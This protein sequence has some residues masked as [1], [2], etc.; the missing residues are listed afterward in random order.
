MNELILIVE[1]NESILFNL[2][3][4]LEMND[5]Q[6][7]TATDA[8]QA[9]EILKNIEELPDLIL[10]DIMMP[11]LNGYEFFE[12]ISKDKKLNHIPFVF[13]SAKSLPSDIQYG[14]FIGVEDY[15][16]KP[17]NEEQM[18]SIIRNKLQKAY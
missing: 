2:K 16:T 8:Y 4:S 15:I 9:I 3:I 6:V 1:D 12:I 13:V 17:I 7:K 11:E 5:Y 10:S 14:K 18:L